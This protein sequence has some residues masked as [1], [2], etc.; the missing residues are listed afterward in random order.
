MGLFNF[1]KEQIASDLTP[2]NKRVSGFLRFLYGLLE[3]VKDIFFLSEKSYSGYT[4]VIDIHNIV[5]TYSEGQIVQDLASGIVY[6]SLINF[7]TDT[8]DNTSSW[9]KISA[10]NIGMGESVKYNASIITLTYALNKRYQTTFQ[11]D[12]SVAYSDINI[13]NIADGLD[14][15]QIG[16]V[17]ANSSYINAANPDSSDGY[18][19]AANTTS[20]Q[21]GFTVSVPSGWWITYFSTF[22]DC[23]NSIRNYLKPL[24]PIGLFYEVTDY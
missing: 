20:Y 11:D 10:S 7:N 18:I 9:R 6:E 21:Q 1:N 24:V 2:N 16:G 12:P 23:E 22:T 17:E 15:F 8:L 19:C 14:M 13:I 4:D 5:S 3:G